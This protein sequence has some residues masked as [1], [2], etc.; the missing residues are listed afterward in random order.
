MEHI[1]VC[2][3]KG[4][5][6]IDED[7]ESLPDRCSMTFLASYSMLFWLQTNSSCQLC[8]QTQ[9]AAVYSEKALMNPS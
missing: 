6:C 3:V 8:F 9:Q 4:I 1:T 2:N 7:R 5:V